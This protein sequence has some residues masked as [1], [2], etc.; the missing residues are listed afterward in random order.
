MNGSSPTASPSA[1]VKTVAT[2]NSDTNLPY[3]MWRTMNAREAV[4]QNFAHIFRGETAKVVYFF[5]VV[6]KM[7]YRVLPQTRVA[8]VTHNSVLICTS[9]AQVTRHIAIEH[10]KELV[11]SPD[12]WLG[13]V[14][15][16]YKEGG[17]D[18]LLSLTLA[19]QEQLKHIICIVYKTLHHGEKTL[20]VTALTPSANIRKNVTLRK[21]DGWVAGP[22]L[23]LLKRRDVL[24]ASYRKRSISRERPTSSASPTRSNS[25]YPFKISNDESVREKGL[26]GESVDRDDEGSITPLSPMSATSDKDERKEAAPQGTTHPPPLPLWTVPVEEEVEVLPLQGAAPVHAT[27]PTPPPPAHKEAPQMASFLADNDGPTAYDLRTK[28]INAHKR[29][30]SPSSPRRDGYHPDD[31]VWIREKVNEGERRAS[32]SPNSVASTEEGDDEPRWAIAKVLLSHGADHMSVR[33]SSGKTTTISDVPHNVRPYMKLTNGEALETVVEVTTEGGVAIPVGAVGVVL[34]VPGEDAGTA[35]VAEIDGMLVSLRPADFRTTTVA[36]SSTTIEPDNTNPTRK[37]SP[38][39]PPRSKVFEQ[40]FPEGMQAEVS[41]HGVW[42]PCTV[43]SREDD[44]CLVETNES[45]DLLSLNTAEVT[46]R[47][48]LPPSNSPPPTT[49]HSTPP[50]PMQAPVKSISGGGGGGGGAPG[51]KM[52]KITEE[53][54]IHI[55]NLAEE[56]ETLSYRGLLEGAPAAYNGSTTGRASPHI[57]PPPREGV[58]TSAVSSTTPSPHALHTSNAVVEAAVIPAKVP[59][60]SLRVHS[61]SPPKQVVVEREPTPLRSYSPPKQLQSA[62]QQSLPLYAPILEEMSAAELSLYLEEALC[63]NA[64]VLQRFKGICGATAAGYTVHDLEVL[65]KGLGGGVVGML[66]QHLQGIRGEWVGV[67]ALP[68]R[69]R[70]AAYVLAS[71][72]ALTKD[73]IDIS[74]AARCLYSNAA[75][76]RKGYVAAHSNTTMPTARHSPAVAKLVEKSVHLERDAALLRDATKATLSNRLTEREKVASGLARHPR[77]AVGDPSLELDVPPAGHL[78]PFEANLLSK[79]DE[80]VVARVEAAKMRKREHTWAQRGE[81]AKVKEEYYATLSPG[82][83]GGGSGGG[84]GGSAV[85]SA[86]R[87]GPQ[88]SGSSHSPAARRRTRSATR[89]PSRGRTVS[90]PV[91]LFKRALPEWK[92]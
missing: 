54:P 58:S 69:L 87:Q 52:P 89:S 7:A 68:E 33:F 16:R 60:G 78:T 81:V 71:R 29:S 64:A 21:P 42:T 47:L 37:H 1:E 67:H 10:I 25:P 90:P 41:I 36:S 65:L 2:V 26:L 86:R 46:E 13:I 51:R 84:A 66:H 35:C 4:K 92:R 57:A 20:T 62:P 91:R 74:S 14:V 5:E 85:L 9:D 24:H 77:T 11:V 63:L 12:H 72:N 34:A 49:L 18:V 38:S 75:K 61:P 76:L 80:Q 44:G 43:V 45:L 82:G 50:P 79:L 19:Q 83:G 28:E 39:P 3:I 53:A 8:M 88:R 23:P 56:E 22:P 31:F 55:A 40:S 59:E 48:R 30:A 73:L 15:D 70:Y 32:V 6:R 27:P 17:H